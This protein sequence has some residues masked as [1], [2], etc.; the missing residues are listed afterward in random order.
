MSD[1]PNGLVRKLT[2]ELDTEWEVFG[3]SYVAHLL[4][5]E[6]A[7]M[8]RELLLRHRKKAIKRGCMKE[9]PCRS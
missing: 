5:D 6:G 8:Y 1:I 7:D 4:G 2:A 3:N 9:H